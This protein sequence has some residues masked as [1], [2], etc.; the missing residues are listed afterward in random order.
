MV[1]IAENLEGRQEGTIDIDIDEQEALRVEA[2]GVVW[3]RSL[4]E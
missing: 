3:R 4:R 2:V 1:A